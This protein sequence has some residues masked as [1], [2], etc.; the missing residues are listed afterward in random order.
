M[1]QKSPDPL[2]QGAVSLRTRSV[3]MDHGRVA[4][5]VMI[6]LNDDGLVPVGIRGTLFNDGLLADGVIAVAV[7]VDLYPGR[8][9]SDAY[10]FGCRR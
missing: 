2:G 3:V 6:F 5:T 10:F 4:I 7:A 1:T 9:N 8:T